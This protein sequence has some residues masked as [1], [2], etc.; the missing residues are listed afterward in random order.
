MRNDTRCIAWIS[1]RVSTF[2]FHSVCFVLIC[3]HYFVYQF[4]SFIWFFLNNLHSYIYIIY[5]FGFLLECSSNPKKRY[6]LFLK[7]TQLDVIIEKLDASMQ[8]VIFAKT[9]Y[10]A[11]QKQHHNYLEIQK[12]AHE[13]LNQFRSMEPLKVCKSIFYSRAR[14]IRLVLLLFT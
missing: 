10:K 5:Y 4:R 9:E 13:K 8:Q 1:T 7:A 11:Q 6:E 3:L 12:K 14:F 2:L